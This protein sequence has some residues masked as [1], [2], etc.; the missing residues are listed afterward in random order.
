MDPPKEEPLHLQKKINMK[1]RM[2]KVRTPI[3]SR[4]I[5]KR[6]GPYLV[7]SVC[8][9]RKRQRMRSQA[10]DDLPAC[11]APPCNGAL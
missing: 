1:P 11:H 8:K 9:A 7:M 2:G 6:G 4:P 3:T 10:A 5:R